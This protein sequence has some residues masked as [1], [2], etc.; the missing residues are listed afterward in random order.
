MERVIFI[1]AFKHC[2]ISFDF[3]VV[4][5]VYFHLS[6]STK[7]L[8]E[9]F[10]FWHRVPQHLHSFIFFLTFLVPRTVLAVRGSRER[11]CFGQ[12][13]A[14][15]ES[16]RKRGQFSFSFSFSIW[17][18]SPFPAFVTF[19]SSSFSFIFASFFLLPSDE[20]LIEISERYSS[21]SYAPSPPIP[22]L[23]ASGFVLDP[24]PS[25]T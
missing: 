18:L 21:S 25:L 1:A 17:F 16:E 6:F 7:I 15:R 11:S 5:I 23:V 22:D 8:N 4:F 12:P 10:R 14:E 20:I 24:A 3:I 2:Y 9:I 19:I 13:L